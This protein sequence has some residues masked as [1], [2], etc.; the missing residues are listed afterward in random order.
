MELIKALRALAL[1]TG[2][3]VGTVAYSTK[4]KRVTFHARFLVKMSGVV[5]DNP[6]SK[7][8]VPQTWGKVTVESC[9]LPFE[10][11][12]NMASRAFGKAFVAG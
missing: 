4:R 12:A 10:K 9:D 11:A 3:A 2:L 8:R 5:W 7:R 6:R 1:F